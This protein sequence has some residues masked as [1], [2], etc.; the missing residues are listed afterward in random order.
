MLLVLTP[1]LGSVSTDTSTISYPSM[2]LHHSALQIPAQVEESL[3]HLCPFNCFFP[4]GWEPASCWRC[5]SRK[6]QVVLC[7]PGDSEDK[8][9]VRRLPGPHWP[10]S[11]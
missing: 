4:E 10:S 2:T 5:C 8:C 9:R 11:L 6:G 1:D 3:S 7:R